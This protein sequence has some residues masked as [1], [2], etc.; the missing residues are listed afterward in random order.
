MLV[1][2]TREAFDRLIP[3]IATYPQYQFYWGQP[4][5]F[6]RRLAISVVGV[7]VT[8]LF[9]LATGEATGPLW[10][11]IGF[12]AALYW[13]WAPV[14]LASQRNGKSRKL[15]YCGFWEGEIL[16]VYVTEELVG[17]EE[18]VNQQG[19]LVIVENRERCINLEVGDNT[20]FETRL[21]APLRRD[22]KGIKPGM[23]A[24]TLILSDRPDLSR[25]SQVADFYLPDRSLW[26]SDYPLL[27]R[28][29]F[30]EVSR[31]LTDPPRDRRSRRANRPDAPVAPAPVGESRLARR[32]DPRDRAITRYDATIDRGIAAD[33]TDPDFR[34]RYRDPG[35]DD[36]PRFDRADFDST[37]EDEDTAPRD[38]D[39]RTSRRRTPPNSPPDRRPRRKPRPDRP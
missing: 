37:F 27:Q 4:T 33:A 17:Q 10:F 24:Q 12:A 25:V 20:G 13:F 6:I 9:S 18:T 22:H 15:G 34:D 8:W 1:P 29:A 5:D 3:P 23:R 21:Q 31:E 28:E 30:E 16:D 14:Y 2:L 36:D 7:V 39:P 11:M 35:F 32:P 26:V 38:R 19:E